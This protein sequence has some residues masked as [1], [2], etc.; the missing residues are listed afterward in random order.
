MNVM[1]Q[2]GSCLVPVE[3]ITSGYIPEPDCGGAAA[4][5]QGSQPGAAGPRWEHAASCSL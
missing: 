1:K 3:P 2:L 4:G 5:G